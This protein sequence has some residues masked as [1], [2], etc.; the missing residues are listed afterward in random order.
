MILA[1]LAFDAEATRLF[2]KDLLGD[3]VAAMSPELLPWERI[4]GYQEIANEAALKELG[5]LRPKG[6][7]K[8]EKANKAARK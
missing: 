1:A 8:L 4:K 7:G 6:T 3:N 2:L 5:P